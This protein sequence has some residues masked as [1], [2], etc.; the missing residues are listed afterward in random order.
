[1]LGDFITALLFL[2]RCPSVFWSSRV[3]ERRGA[4]GTAN[5]YA[6]REVVMAP[7]SVSVSRS[8]LTITSDCFPKHL[9]PIVKL[10]FTGTE[11]IHFSGL[12]LSGIGSMLVHSRICDLHCLKCEL[13]SRVFHA[14]QQ[15]SPWNFLQC[16]CF[17][18]GGR[19]LGPPRCV[20]PPPPK[21]SS[22]T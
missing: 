18:P 7:R 6:S 12:A 19:T 10:H 3:F 2:A 5:R 21:S 11:K 20:S 17:R 9:C 1:M 4:D 13:K 14:G 16:S 8:C 15:S 22:R